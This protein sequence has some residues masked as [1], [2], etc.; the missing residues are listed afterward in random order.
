MFRY[1]TCLKLRDTDAAGVAFFASYYAM[2]HDAYEAFLSENGRPLNSWLDQVHLPI[3]HSEA[4]YQAPLRLADPFDI[5]LTCLKIGERSFTMAYLFCSEGE[6][7]ASV[8]TVHVAVQLDLNSKTKAV[9]LPAE[10]IGL[11]RLIEVGA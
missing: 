8:K 9:S 10:L 7:L 3:V 11:L 1:S 5:E 2:A 6:V 4:D